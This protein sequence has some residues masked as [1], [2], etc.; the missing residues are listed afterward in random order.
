[1]NRESIRQV[2]R[3]R[4]SLRHGCIPPRIRREI[5][6]ASS[7]AALVMGGAVVA[8]HQGSDFAVGISAVRAEES[9]SPAGQPGTL[10]SAKDLTAYLAPGL[11]PAPTVLRT[12]VKPKIPNL[13]KGVSVD[14][15]DWLSEHR[16]ALFIRSAA[17]PEELIQVQMLLARDWYLT[18]D[19]TFPE[20]WALDGMRSSDAENGWTLSTNIEDFFADK[21]INV[22]LPV[23]GAASFY[24]D[25]E[26][27]ANG[28]NYKWE[29]FLINE[30]APIVKNGYRSNGVRAIVGPSMGGTAA[31]NLAEHHPEMFNFVG[32]YSGYLDTTTEGMPEAIAAAQRDIGD[33]DAK[34]MWGELG[35][36]R[37][38][39]NDPKLSLENLKGKTVYVSAGNGVSDFGEKDAIAAGPSNLGGE[40]LEIVSRMTAQT[41]I[42]RAKA[43]GVE[44]VAKLRDAGV[45]S[46]EFWQFELTQGWGLMADALKIDKTGRG[47]N[48]TPIGAIAEATQ[49]GSAGRC[50]NNEYEV[51]GGRAEDFTNGTAYWSPDTGA[52]VL[53]G[54]I[55]KTYIGMGATDS[56]L[57]FPTTSELGAGKN[58][59]RVH[60]ENG[61]LYWS[62]ETG[63]HAIPQAIFDA[64]G[65][66][67][68]E[69]GEL[70][71]PVAEAAAGAAGSEAAAGAGAETDSGVANAGGDADKAGDSGVDK[72]NAQKFQGGWIIVNDGK[73]FALTGETATLWERLGALES[74][75]GLPVEE[76][77]NVGGGQI[78]K[79]ARGMIYDHPA[80]GAY[81]VPFGEIFDYWGRNGYEGGKFG[82]PVSGLQRIPAGGEFITF[83]HGTI[84]QINGVVSEKDAPD[85]QKR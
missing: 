73:A 62:P 17:M 37:W 61:S 27:P 71:L 23:G 19:A 60:F 1:M 4:V 49:D 48:C 12:D 75:V 18:P 57:G 50:I 44:V 66:Q 80:S 33:Y 79:F 8:P 11:K 46:W 70:G 53:V 63:T 24:T 29:S 13:P 76:T 84:Q 20:L 51:A 58:S 10:P 45:H 9:Q 40:G 74:E 5:I 43:A 83:Q 36:Q 14:H 68:W 25:W 64:W 21:N 41:F 56:W 38:K 30:L 72:V 6:A 85:E 77:R 59:R 26:G 31:V 81:Y 78:T 47:T 32:S 22:I 65:A 42:N 39:D 52:H 16:V 35:S 28:K 15:V 67:G 34:N 55:R 69:N 82:W 7:I 54:D 3:K 2:S